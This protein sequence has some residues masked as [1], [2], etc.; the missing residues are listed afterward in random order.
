VISVVIPVKNGGERLRRCLEAIRGQS[1]EDE[2]EVIVVDSGS[3]DGSQELARSLGAAVHEIPP[4]AFN[5]GA[6][7][8]LGAQL[9]GG[10]IVVF[11][12]DD[13]LPVGDT[14]L[15][16]L[17]APLRDEDD[18]AGTYSRQIAYDDAPPHQ[19][20][21][22]D[23][24]YGPEARIQRAASPSELT[25]ANTLFSDVSSA[26]RK[27]ILERFPFANDIVIAEDLE[28][29]SR[30]LL[31]GYAIAYVP[32]SVVRHSHTYSLAGIFKRYFDQGAAAEHSY[33]A[34]GRSS[35]ASVRGEGLAFVLRELGWL[36]RSG[37][38]CHIPYA[39]AHE[40]TRYSAFR[41]GV[42]HR[43]VPRALRRR[44]SRTSVYWEDSGASE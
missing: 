40:A 29:A 28:W 42:R 19:R 6:T 10:E 1:I 15:E 41:L 35:P 12:V 43:Q 37:Q 8:T 18:V 38:R 25:V 7:R 16:A 21:Y 34:A 26:I 4:E 44:I 31:A 5:H 23:Y 33:M 39:L 11:T 24:R 2:V 30:V 20:F 27:S 9:A 17:T 14:W 32:D 3:T 36:W 13:A 22:I